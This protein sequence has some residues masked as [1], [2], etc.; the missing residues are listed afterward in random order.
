MQFIT[1]KKYY[2]GRLNTSEN[3]LR[4]TLNLSVVLNQNKLF[5]VDMYVSFQQEK[6]YSNK[7]AFPLSGLSD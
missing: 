4:V 7:P 2:S 6:N 1:K 3:W 5:A